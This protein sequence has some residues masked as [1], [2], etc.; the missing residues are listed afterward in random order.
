MDRVTRFRCPKDRPDAHA[1]H[2]A[3][4]ADDA[5]REG[6][7]VVESESVLPARLR[8]VKLWE[9]INGKRAPWSSNPWVW[10]VAFERVTP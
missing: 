6:V 10:R 3:I 4:D 8:F 9:M 7:M 1:Q 2:L 5:M